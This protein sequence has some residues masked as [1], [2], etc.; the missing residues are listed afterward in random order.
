MAKPKRIK[1][2]TIMLFYECHGK[3]AEVAMDK[4]N[5]KVQIVGDECT[6]TPEPQ[7]DIWTEFT[8]SICG[9]EH[10]VCNIQDQFTKV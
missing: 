7:A 3:I 10:T 4:T 6:S 8:C 5:T 1:Q 9:K 2:F